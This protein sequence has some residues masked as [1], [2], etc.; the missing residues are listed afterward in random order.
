M[1]S[2][3]INSESDS[4]S[5][6]I[7]FST[8]ESAMQ[9]LMHDYKEA[10]LVNGKISED[11]YEI[12]CEFAD[13]FTSFKGRKRFQK[14]LS[15]FARFCRNVTLQVQQWEEI[16]P[17]VEFQSKMPLCVRATW[18]FRCELELPWNPVLACRGRTTHVFSAETGKISKHIEKWYIEPMD[19]LK[20]VFRPGRKGKNPED[21][22]RNIESTRKSEFGGLQ[23]RSFGV[24][25]VPI[26]RSVKISNSNACG[27]LPSIM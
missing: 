26:P 2:S 15:N 27:I 22:E 25:M 19:A 21:K 24:T 4:E 12:N 17:D 5:K 1:D 10:Y 20:Q 11:L 3:R 16:E 23:L 14:N 13:P 8:R 6:V 7:Q 18:K 9:A